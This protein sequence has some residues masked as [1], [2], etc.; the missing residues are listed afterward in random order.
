M[1]NSKNDQDNHT[2]IHTSN[3]HTHTH[4][5]IYGRVYKSLIIQGL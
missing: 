3:T 1:I 2:D 4:I 5:Y